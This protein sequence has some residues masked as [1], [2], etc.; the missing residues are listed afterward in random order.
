MKNTRPLVSVICL[1]FNH[2]DYVEDSVRSVLEQTYDMVELIVVD[3]GSRDESREIIA[4]M[5]A[6]YGF[7]TIFNG[8]NMGNCR[9]FNKALARAHGDYIIDLA[10]DDMLMPERIERGV[11]VFSE[12]GEGF[13]V[14][15]CDV[16]LAGPEGEELGT[17]YRRDA[18]GKLLE[19]VPAG[20]VYKDV[21]ERYF[22]STP[23]MMMRRSVFDALGGYDESLSYEDFDFWVRA[24]RK[25]KFAFT[26]EILVK[27]HVLPGSM[28]AAQKQYKN[29][30]LLSTASVCKKALQL[31][32][33]EAE[34]NA[35]ARRCAYELKW[36]LITEN[37]D[38]AR[39]FCDIL[40]ELGIKPAIY[41]FAILALWLKP[42]WY[43]LWR[44]LLI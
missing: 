23:S 27:K 1:C 37:W 31:N 10:A 2:A 3:D 25:F 43:G 4:R 34:N 36:A 17:H 39:I 8:E 15:F 33:N 5:A 19:D 6:E 24:S 38:A 32:K 35:L 26:D 11:W 28:S 21:L 20:D 42:C 18:S 7:D 13:G 40:G 29:P 30:H 22:I 16:A 9:A 12:V 14:H 44:R 41:R